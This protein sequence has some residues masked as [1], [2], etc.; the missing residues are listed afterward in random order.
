MFTKQHTNTCDTVIM[1]LCISSIL[2]YCVEVQ[3][4]ANLIAA[5]SWM[6]T[7][8]AEM[9]GGNNVG[10][11]RKLMVTLCYDDINHIHDE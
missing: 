4:C 3:Y 2:L 6:V 10:K 5:T 7:Q 11:T 9:F 8:V 1:N